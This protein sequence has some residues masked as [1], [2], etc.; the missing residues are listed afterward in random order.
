MVG[1]GSGPDN[2]ENMFWRSNF[3]FWR[4][5]NWYFGTAE[6]IWK[7]GRAYNLLYWKHLVL[8]WTLNILKTMS[9]RHAFW[10]YLKRLVNCRENIE[11]NVSK[12]CILTVFKTI[13]NCREHFKNNVFKACALKVF[14][15]IWNCREKIRR[16]NIYKACI[17]VVSETICGTAEK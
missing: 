14:E 2:I 6:T 13:W 5:L 3:T 9:L 15:T 7:Q 4:Y 17:L 8:L 10:W 11:S 16:T 12:A 1:W